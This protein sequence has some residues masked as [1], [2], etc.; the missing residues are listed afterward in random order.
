MTYALKDLPNTP[1]KKPDGIF[2]VKTAK[3]SGLL[4]DSG[5]ANMTAVKLTEKDSGSKEVRIDGLCG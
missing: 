5:V 1:F 4:S 3:M 2:D